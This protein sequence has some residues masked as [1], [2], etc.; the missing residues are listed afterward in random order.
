LLNVE[1]NRTLP[2]FKLDIALS[3]NGEVLG[4][5]GPSGSGKTMTLLCIA[6]LIHPDSGFI[7]LND[8]VLFDSSKKLNLQPKDRNVG[9]VFQNYALFPHLSAGNNIAYGIRRQPRDEVNRRVQLL[10]ENMGL[11]GLQ[12]RYPSELSAGQQ[13]RVA[14]ARAL[15]PE[16]DILLLDEPFSALDSLTKEQLEM[17]I[18]DL[19]QFYKG[20]I[21]LVTHDLAEAY[22]LSSRIAVYDAGKIAQCDLKEKLISSPVNRT[23]A[24]ITRFRNF[25][26]GVITGITD[27]QVRVTVP[28]LDTALIV[29]VNGYRNLS[30]NQSIAIGIRS[31]HIQAVHGPGQNTIQGTLSSTVENLASI[32]CFFDLKTNKDKRYRLE[33]AFT[34]GA[35]S[36]FANGLNYYLHLPPEQIVIITK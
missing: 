8:R 16:P 30:I 2:G 12:N 29:A 21:I 33:A 36:T 1:I 24:R 31:E 4:I 32:N 3:V 25:M 23:V 5:L 26:D 6:G 28:D 20:H 17:Q 34:R 7:Q 22:R 9:F 11:S 19:R 18:L 15:A 10:I 14:V 13:Q 35:E 27:K